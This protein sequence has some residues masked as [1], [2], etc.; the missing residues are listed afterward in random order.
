MFSGVG[1]QVFDDQMQATDGGLAVRQ[2]AVRIYFFAI[3]R[4]R[5]GLHNLSDARLI[6]KSRTGCTGISV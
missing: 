2:A 5:W 1:K 6:K 4:S 3:F